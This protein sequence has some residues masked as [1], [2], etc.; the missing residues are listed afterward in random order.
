MVCEGGAE[1]NWLRIVS[2]PEFDDFSCPVRGE[3]S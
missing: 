1:F 2:G 3:N